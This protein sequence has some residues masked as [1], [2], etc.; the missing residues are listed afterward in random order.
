MQKSQGYWLADSEVCCVF[1]E[2]EEAPAGRQQAA[3]GQQGVSPELVN[4]QMLMQHSGRVPRPE[5][6]ASA[7]RSDAAPDDASLV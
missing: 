5:A 3:L 6:A 2:D 7:G 4:Q 1:A